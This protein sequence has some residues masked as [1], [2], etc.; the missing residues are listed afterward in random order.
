MLQPFQKVTCMSFDGNT[1]FCSPT[2]I[3]PPD[4]VQTYAKLAALRSMSE[5]DFIERHASGTL[6]KAKRIGMDY[7]DQYMHERVAYEFGWVFESVPANRVSYRKAESAG[8]CKAITEA[9]WH[10]ER[11]LERSVF[12]EDKFCVGYLGISDEDGNVISEGIGIIVL[13]TS[14]QFIPTGHVVCGIVAPRSACSREYA[15]AINPA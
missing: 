12:H 8:D 2:T 7:F 10:I 9:S 13:E 1:Q 5:D 14:A 6:R 4:L 15:E 3:V 11:Y